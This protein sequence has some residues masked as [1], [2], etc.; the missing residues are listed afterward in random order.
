LAASEFLIVFG[1]AA[2]SY[3]FIEHPILSLKRYAKYQRSA[4][5]TY[6]SPVSPSDSVSVAPAVI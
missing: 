2:L 3:R 4:S 5:E 6:L 1:V